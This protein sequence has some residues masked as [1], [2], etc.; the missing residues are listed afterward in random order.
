MAQKKAHEVD[1]WLR[2]PDPRA[3][4]VLVYGPDHGMVAE[5]AAA[6]AAATG[7]ALDDPFSVTRLDGSEAEEPG[8]LVD[9]A[10]TVPMFAARR[11]LWVR[12]VSQQKSIADA[13]KILCEAPPAD[14][15]VLLEAGD[16]K[17]GSALRANIEASSAAMAL[18]CYA[19]EARDIERLIDEAMESAGIRLTMD[20]RMLLKRNLGGD[21]LG[22]RAEL[23]KLALY[24]QG[25]PVIEVEDVAALT[26]DVAGRSVDEVVD[27]VLTGQLRD[28]DL[29]FQRHVQGGGHTFLLVSA[30]MRQLYA[31]QVMRAALD[32]GNRGAS[33]IVAAARPPVF[34]ARKKAVEAALRRLRAPVIAR[35][36]DRLGAALL[37]SRRR[38]DLGEAIVRQALL[39]IAVE[40]ARAA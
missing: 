35:G 23:E 40:S 5:R 38:P 3:A 32:E 18:P 6:F 7:I 2:R 8:R 19:D 28:F 29:M 16:L 39:G 24:A 1:S 33:E 9:E 11:L 22:T 12:N 13:V 36:L 25:K 14:A 26:G 34:F 37:E 21:R 4:V 31:L 15:V 30:A 17:K 10:F 20:A 27:A